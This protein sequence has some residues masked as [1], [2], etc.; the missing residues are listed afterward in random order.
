MRS[1][2]YGLMTAMTS[3]AIHAAA[4]PF[5]PLYSGLYEVGGG[6]DA[7]FVKIDDEA[8]FS[9]TLWNEST[10]KYGPSVGAQQIKEFAWGTGIWGITDWNLAMGS[11][12]GCSSFGSMV[13]SSWCGV[14]STIN[15]GNAIYNSLYSTQWGLAGGIPLT[16]GQGNHVPGDYVPPRDDLP[17]GIPRQQNWAAEFTGFI[18]VSDAGAYNF[19]VLYDDGFF[20]EL[21]G[22]NGQSLRI[23]QDFLNPRDREGFDN[24]LDL[25]VG[26][27]GFR[28]GAYNRLEAGVVDLRWREGDCTAGDACWEP[29]PTGN[30]L[31][32]NQ[33]PEPSGLALIGLALVGLAAASRRRGRRA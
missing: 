5:A 23:D 25:G 24:D 11:G 7:R 3:A 21:I 13:M 28:L 2:A 16:F 4:V 20:F 29:V 33:V 22:A 15:Y 12:T 30:L 14:V 27:Y 26:V 6:A 9:E 10:K 17:V 32:R 18:R 1:I 31:R 8:R 19:S